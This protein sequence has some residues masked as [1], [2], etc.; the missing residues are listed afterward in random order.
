MNI[1]E[2]KGSIDLSVEDALKK[3]DVLD[4][5]LNKF[6]NGQSND[7]SELANEMKSLIGTMG[8][9]YTSHMNKMKSSFDGLEKKY[10]DYGRRIAKLEKDQAS[11]SVKQAERRSKGISDAYDRE[12]QRY[13]RSQ[14]RLMDAQRTLTVSKVK[15][16]EDRVGYRN[17][18]RARAEER[19]KQ[20]EIEEHAEATFM[21]SKRRL[22]ELAAQKKAADDLDW[23]FHLAQQARMKKEAD[24]HKRLQREKEKELKRSLARRKAM[25]KGFTSTIAKTLKGIVWSPVIVNQG[26]QALG[27]ISRTIK[28]LWDATYGQIIEVGAQIDSYMARL[29]VST[30]SLGAAKEVWKDI[31]S[32]AVKSVYSFQESVDSAAALLPVLAGGREEL[33]QWQNVIADIAAGFNLTYQEATSNFIKLYSAGAAAADLFRERGVL[34]ALGFT[35]GEKVSGKDSR[36]VLMESWQSSTSVFR[37]AASELARTWNGIINKIKDQWF[38]FVKDIGEVGIFRTLKVYLKSILDFFENLRSSG[39]DYKILIT[40]ISEAL[41]RFFKM[42]MNGLAIIL[43]MLEEAMNKKT[44]GNFLFDILPDE[45]KNVLQRVKELSHDL[46]QLKLNEKI[47]PSPDLTE[48][49]KKVTEELETL[50]KKAEEIKNPFQR[51][52]SLLSQIFIGSE[53]TLEKIKRFEEHE[54]EPEV[55]ARIEKGKKYDKDREDKNREIERQNRINQKIYD[56]TVSAAEAA[57]DRIA[58]ANVTRIKAFRGEWAAASAQAGIEGKKFFNKIKDSILHDG[59]GE[60]SEERAE[61]EARKHAGGLVASLMS[62]KIAEAIAELVEAKRSVQEEL[63]QLGMSQYEREIFDATKMEKDLKWI[64]APPQVKSYLKELIE[65]KIEL[66]NTTR[67]IELQA[68]AIAHEGDML[69]ATIPSWDE[70]GKK[71]SQIE[72][73]FEKG[74]VGASKEKIKDLELARDRAK[75]LLDVQTKLSYVERAEDLRFESANVYST[76]KEKAK[77]ELDRDIARIMSSEGAVKNPKEAK[78]LID[79]LNEAYDLSYPRTY[80]DGVKAAFKDIREAAKTDGE[81]I[82]DLLVDI[83]GEL[84]STLEDV[85]FSAFEGRVKDIGKAFEDFGKAVMR[86]MMK[87]VATQAAGS[88]MDGLKGVLKFHSGGVVG[89]DGTNTMVSPLAFIGAPRYHSG[90]IAG[91]APNEVPAILKKGEIVIPPE[92]M[93]SRGT[94]GNV[95]V[96]IKNESGQALAVTKATSSQD[97]SGTILE[98]VI[99]GIARNR[100]GLRDMMGAR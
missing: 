18:Q 22:A 87:M 56:A 60:V 69:Q 84:S 85:F 88:I 89:Q 27:T 45:D 32:F 62:G 14:A 7:M 42:L 47:E 24:A 90:G 33:S 6:I 92:K 98:I 28:G 95:N 19:R 77:N 29:R 11:N 73:E 79:A 30:G 86:T 21:A 100:M 80:A 49:I 20:Q 61:A 59:A 64:G 1:D 13:M 63:V 15:D 81:A 3:L 55:R 66:A 65:A 37:G 52:V 58:T 41:E 43:G 35:P 44:G 54:M 68:A 82:R 78:E 50:R 75:E 16:R 5:R 48:R 34:A 97:M 71:L 83:F 8:D 76:S 99:D 38:M 12:V 57:S 46:T 96:S 40:S 26:F 2:I 70:Y 91:L 23:Q 74:I 36:K 39:K 53:T 31:E 4:K 10:R 51:I 25:Y 67:Q 72:F 94:Q 93:R 17:E 9:T